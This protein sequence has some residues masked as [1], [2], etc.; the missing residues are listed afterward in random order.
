M[1]QYSFTPAGPQETHI[2]EP[3]EPG[4]EPPKPPVQPPKPIDDPPKPGRPPKPIDDPP[5]RPDKPNKPKWVSRRW[6]E[7]SQAGAAR[8]LGGQG[9]MICG[10]GPAG[11]GTG[12]VNRK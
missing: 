6:Q 11:R 1:R 3:P 2:P 9:F 12:P 7:G 8:G 4:K 5:R 10:R